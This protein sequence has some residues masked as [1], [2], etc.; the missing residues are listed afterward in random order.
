MTLLNN[1]QV[2]ID[3]WIFTEYID[4]KVIDCELGRLT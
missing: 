1:N 4:E 2:P 3:L